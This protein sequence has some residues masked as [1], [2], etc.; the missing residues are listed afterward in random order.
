VPIDGLGA[1]FFFAK[2]SFNEEPFFSGY[3][4]WLT[5]EYLEDGPSN[6]LRA[7]IDA[8]GLAGLSN[9]SYTAELESKSKEQYCNAL[10]ALKKLLIDP[11]RVT[12]N[13]T[14]MAVILLILFEVYRAMPSSVLGRAAHRSTDHQFPNLGS[15]SLLGSP[16]QGGCCSA[17]ASGSETI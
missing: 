9:V 17:R 3:H 11:A 2:Y 12:E 10:T 13:V 16:C 8:V 6:V 15:I 1:S 5:H 4:A 7:A 14:L